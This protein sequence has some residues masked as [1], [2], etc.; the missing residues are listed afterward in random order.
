MYQN[1]N[2]AQNEQ[3]NN[4]LIRRTRLYKTS[5]LLFAVAFLSVGFAM[6]YSSGTISAT[7]KFKPTIFSEDQGKALAHPT[8]GIVARVLV[9]E[10]QKV[11]AGDTLLVLD[12]G[13]V[14]APNDGAVVGLK[15]IAAGD[16]VDAGAT[17]LAI[18]PMPVLT[19]ET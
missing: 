3:E 16:V 10:G 15:R 17:V 2:S 1:L 14:I 7:A 8:G 5:T 9:R 6:W 18:V 12:A 19:L 4:D 13:E 11:K